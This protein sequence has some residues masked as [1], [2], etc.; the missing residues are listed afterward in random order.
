MRLAVVVALALTIGCGSGAEPGD[1][2]GTGG[3]DAGATG[4]ATGG[5]PGTGGAAPVDAGAANGCNVQLATVN[6]NVTSATSSAS[7]TG[8]GPLPQWTACESAGAAVAQSAVKVI[9]G[10]PNG[11]ADWA[12]TSFAIAPSDGGCAASIGYT[13]VGIAYDGGIT[14]NENLSVTVT[15]AP[16]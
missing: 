9:D 16:R 10:Q 5:A 14:C 2:V 3:T 7:F 12:S 11:E 8:S 13:R 4:G 1:Y 15:V 6:G